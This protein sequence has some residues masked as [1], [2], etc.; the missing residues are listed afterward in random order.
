MTRKPSGSARLLGVEAGATRTVAIL[1]ECDRESLE[2][3]HVRELQLGPANLRLLDD[4]HLADHFRKIARACPTLDT[5]AIGMAGARTEADRQRIRRTAAEVWPGV[6]CYATNDLE[7][8]LQAADNPTAVPRFRRLERKH[9]H[10][11]RYL[12]G[13]LA[14]E[15]DTMPR[16][17]ILSG[18][19]S[20]CF[21]QTA[22]GKSAKVG[23]WGHILGDK[24]S[25]FEIG[26]R[27]LKAVVYYHD[28]D[29]EWSELGR[30]ILRK[31]QLN[32][33]DDLIGWVQKAGKD[34]VAA[35]AVEVFTAWSKRDKIA[36]DVL[37]GAADSLAGDALSCARRLVKPGTKVRFVLAGGVLLN[38]PRFARM[39]AALLRKSWPNSVVTPLQRESVWGAVE[40]AKRE[41]QNGGARVLASP[42]VSPNH[43]S[44]R[45]ARSRLSHQYFPSLESLR[46]SPTEQ[47][48]PRSVNLDKLP[49]G[50]AIVLMLS[51]DAKI[52]AAILGQRKKIEQAISLIVRTFQRRGRL[53]YVG[54]GT[55]GRLGVL[56][57]S[58][59][60]PTFRVPPDHVQGIIAGG[61]RALW[62]S[63]EGAEDDATA[64]A[65]AIQ[66]RGVGRKDV[67]VGIAASGR[68]P[69]VWGAFRE[70]GRR[71]AKTVLLCFN[72]HLEIPRRHRPDLVIAPDVGPEILTGSTRLKSGTATKLILNMFT[73][74]AMVQTGKVV[75]NL[76][77]D[78]N[79]SNVKLRDRAVRIV[80]ELTGA[81]PATVAGALEKSGWVVK[82]AYERLR[83]KRRRGRD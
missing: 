1:E 7:T 28:R 3:S 27:A 5:I 45:L 71:G 77:I 42:D 80:R 76:M 73:T 44:A 51:E 10:G 61:N 78:V 74:L 38:Q 16:V 25:G 58:E 17:L 70:A 23:G 34:D 4:K 15:L 18:T 65:R 29:C 41:F 63:V 54:A 79:P 35:L 20:C 66:F 9:P 48:N 37:A 55:S 8:A 19:G 26:L 12:E 56:D 39:L 31:L 60:P 52:P 32:E 11:G 82:K 67:V 49:V 21:G 43:P 69:F 33:P 81:D 50:E 59:C 13:R 46:S 83:R 24:G 40:L 68:T 57:A 6:P 64:G 47:R 53:F 14:D 75:S 62:E 36:S 2:G 30:R 22:D 72:P